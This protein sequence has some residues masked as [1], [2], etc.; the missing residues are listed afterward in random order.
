VVATRKHVATRLSIIVEVDGKQRRYRALMQ[1]GT[2]GGWGIAFPDFRDCVSAG[3][4]VTE[5]VEQGRK[6]LALH[7]RGMLAD[8]N[9]IPAASDW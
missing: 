6:A 4:T 3:D 1:A 8:G 5:T 2:S 7:I 9:P